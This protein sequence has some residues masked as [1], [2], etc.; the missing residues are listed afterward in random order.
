MSMS[1]GDLLMRTS[2]S[3]SYTSL[4][5][6]RVEAHRGRKEQSGCMSFTILPSSHTEGSGV[7]RDH[8][9]RLWKWFKRNLKV[10]INVTS[11]IHDLLRQE[12]TFDILKQSRSY[13]VSQEVPFSYPKVNS[14]TV[15]I[16][17][18]NYVCAIS[19]PV[20]WRD[21]FLH[22]IF[23]RPSLV[24]HVAVEFD[25]NRLFSCIIDIFL[26]YLQFY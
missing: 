12:I 16:C 26:Y 21:I 22:L 18:A 5:S 10:D 1:H 3:L 13:C 11:A 14:L 6:N 20:H 4:A 15:I 8:R 24:F 23:W 2:F 17:I 19:L 7:N 25:L 9:M